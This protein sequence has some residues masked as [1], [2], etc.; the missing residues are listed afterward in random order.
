MERYFEAST[1]IEKSVELLYQIEDKEERQ[2]IL[3]KI[4]TSSYMKEYRDHQ[5]MRGIHHFENFGKEDPDNICELNTDFFI[6]RGICNV[7]P[8]GEQN[9]VQAKY[10]KHN[11]IE[12][13]YVYR[14]Q[15]IQFINGVKYVHNKGD[16]CILNTNVPHRDG[17]IHRT[18]FI[19]YLCVEKKYFNKE[20]LAKDKLYKEF[21][22]LLSN[23]E[24]RQNT[25]RDYICFR[26][27]E[28]KLS[29]VIKAMA[30][31]Y[32]E[33]LPGYQNLIKGYMERVLYTLFTYYEREFVSEQIEK[34]ENRI[35]LE[36]DTVMRR[37]VEDITRY[38][39]ADLF[40]YSPDHINRIIKQNTGET[41]S[42]YIKQLRLEKAR[43]LLI[44]DKLSINEIIKRL[45][46][47]NKTYFYK[48]FV[49]KYNLT[50]KVYKE[51]IIDGKNT[52]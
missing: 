24:E 43:E 46:Y 47:N 37:K 14:G 50:P 25:N 26:A 18:D 19:I 23:Q 3:E 41:Y 35:F 21:V 12:F 48:I 52:Y 44:E 7:F 36:I 40:Y 20:Q 13:I 1:E 49:S 16:M 32:H 2:L 28:D 22:W 51:R 11:F 17:P 34:V 29:E 6:N 5:H 39:L 42:A 10:H 33:K 15:Y 45:G 30:K 38:G 31:E 27:K 9:I 8:N 4:F